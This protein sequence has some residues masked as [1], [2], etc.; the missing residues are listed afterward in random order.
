MARRSNSTDGEDVADI[1]CHKRP[2]SL[3]AEKEIPACRWGAAWCLNQ[4]VQCF[5]TDRVA[6]AEAPLTSMR[7]GTATIHA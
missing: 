2:G 4:T 5:R 6:H 1:A 3:G 7:T